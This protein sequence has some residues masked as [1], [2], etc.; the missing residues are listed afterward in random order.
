MRTC[1]KGGGGCSEHMT[2]AS[3]SG[4]LRIKTSSI[5][6]AQLSKLRT[7]YERICQRVTTIKRFSVFVFVSSI[8]EVLKR[9]FQDKTPTGSGSVEAVWWCV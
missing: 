6:T 2:V 7:S 4:E 9:F 8:D 3:R 1:E 5:H